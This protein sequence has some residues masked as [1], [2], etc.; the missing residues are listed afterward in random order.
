MCP[1][2]DIDVSERF[3]NFNFKRLREAILSH[4]L[5]KNMLK[6]VTH[7]TGHKM[8]NFNKGT[9]VLC[10]EYDENDEID[11]FAERGS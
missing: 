4:I 7:P 11:C 8:L 9:F 2:G 10:Y 3:F 1:K 5:I 6:Y